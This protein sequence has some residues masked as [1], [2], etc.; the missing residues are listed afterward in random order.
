M[1]PKLEKLRV[2]Q[3]RAQREL[4]QAQHGSRDW[5]TGSAT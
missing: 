2:E 5:K 3:E 4:E 1:N